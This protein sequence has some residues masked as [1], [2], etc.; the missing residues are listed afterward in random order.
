MGKTLGHNVLLSYHNFSER[1]IINTDARK[2]KLGW[3]ISQNG[4]PMTFY[5]RK[6]TPAQ[7]NY[8]TTERELLSIVETLKDFLKIILG[9]C[10]KLYTE[11]KNISFE[12]FTTEGVLR[13]ILMLEEYSPR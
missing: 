8:T 7:I 2:T 13:W 3:G 6:L 11:N 5:S 10:I 9:H 4:K 12:K 1:L